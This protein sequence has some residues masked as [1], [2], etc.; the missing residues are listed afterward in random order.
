[1]K[2]LLLF[3]MVCASISFVSAQKKFDK[4]SK[5]TSSEIRWWGYK[6]VKTQKLP[7]QEQ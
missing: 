7:T 2:R 5:V 1:M 3:A 6:V 4:V